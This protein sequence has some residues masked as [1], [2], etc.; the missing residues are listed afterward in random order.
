MWQPVKE[1]HPF[2]GVRSAWERSADHM[3][4][5]GRLS[6][7]RPVALGKN[8]AHQRTKAMLISFHEHNATWTT[9]TRAQFRSQMG[10][11]T[12]RQ[13]NDGKIAVM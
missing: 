8:V 11:A 3:P 7:I 6:L 9:F 1:S 2:S 5:K 12:L 4:R 10:M 13:N